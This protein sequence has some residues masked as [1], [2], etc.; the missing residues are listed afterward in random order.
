MHGFPIQFNPCVSFDL[1]TLAVHADDESRAR[2]SVRE[3]A[4]EHQATF[5]A[6]AARKQSASA[7]EYLLQR[8]SPLAHI[9]FCRRISR[10]EA[11]GPHHA[12]EYRKRNSVLEE[13]QRY[14]PEGH[15]EAK[16]GVSGDATPE[17]TKQDMWPGHGGQHALKAAGM[18]TPADWSTPSSSSSS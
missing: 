9:L 15:L 8:S 10:T 1:F 12:G 3:D 5:Q 2:A 6:I 13:G 17:T 7:D 16:P 11:P 14:S 4:V 18:M